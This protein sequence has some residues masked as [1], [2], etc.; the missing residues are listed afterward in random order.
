MKIFKWFGPLR[1]VEVLHDPKSA[2]F[3]SF[4]IGFG[5]MVLL[6]HRPFSTQRTLS[7]P[8]DEVESKVVQHGNKCYRYRAED[9]KCETSD[10][11]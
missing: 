5:L 4:L 8:V 2:A 11:E 6:F 1:I 7:L 10:K 9:S 3:F